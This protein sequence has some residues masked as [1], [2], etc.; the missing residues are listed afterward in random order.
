MGS[1]G[2]HT[3]FDL[4]SSRRIAFPHSIKV[5]STNSSSQHLLLLLQGNDLLLTHG[6]ENSH[7]KVLAFIKASLDAL[8]AVVIRKFEV[9]LHVTVVKH[10]RAETLITDVNKRKLHSLH[11][12]NIH[13]VSGR[14]HILKLLVGE[15]INC[16]KVTLSV[17]MLPSLGRTHI[18]NLAGATLDY[19]VTILADLASFRGVCQRSTGITGFEVCLKFIVR[20]VA[21]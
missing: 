16:D 20:H 8:A 10:Q 13:I 21:R 11:V 1:I 5:R 17:T 7:D 19:H 15:D 9:I 18:D 12:R 3:P 14:N 6:G 4:Q 2:L